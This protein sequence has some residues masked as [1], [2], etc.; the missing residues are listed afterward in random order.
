MPAEL[1]PQAVL[2]LTADRRV[3][4][5]SVGKIVT[6]SVWR[7]A[8]VL[9]TAA[10]Q[11]LRVGETYE[12]ETDYWGGVAM[13][14]S[15]LGDQWQYFTAAMFEGSGN[16]DKIL[17]LREESATIVI[18]EYSGLNI[19][20]SALLEDSDG[21]YTNVLTMGEPQRAAVTPVYYG[22]GFALVTSGELWDGSEIL[23]E[24]ID[25]EAHK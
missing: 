9:E 15:Q 18:G 12:I 6:D 8:A 21:F 13:T 23:L 1:V 3:A 17:Y 24:D 19:P 7:F 11:R 16:M 14:L 25:L 5:A 20:S 10:V 4:T 22:E 2:A